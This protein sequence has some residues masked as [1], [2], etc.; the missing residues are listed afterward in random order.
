MIILIEP[1]LRSELWTRRR[2]AVDETERG[3]VIGGE[4]IVAGEIEG[5][6]VRIDSVVPRVLIVASEIGDSSEFVGAR[7]RSEGDVGWVVGQNGAV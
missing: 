1:P 6:V 4:R 7:E 5:R 2:L 3:I